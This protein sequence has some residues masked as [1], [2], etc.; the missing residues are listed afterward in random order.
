MP[1]YFFGFPDT[2][3]KM[4]KKKFDIAYVG[5]NWFREEEMT[6]FLKA[7]VESNVVKKVKIIG[8]D[9]DKYKLSRTPLDIKIG[10]SVL[11]EKLIRT[12]STGSI[13][14][15]LT[16]RNLLKHKLVTPRMFETFAAD[17]VPLF[18]DNFDYGDKIY[19]GV[20]KEFSSNESLMKDKIKNVIENHKKYIEF[21]NTA[22]KYL[23]SLHSYEN[24]MQELKRI[25]GIN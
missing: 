5:N 15:I 22:R 20:A 7:A 4:P 23:T 3:I 9:W 8:K 12:M 11:P 2:D 17:T 19:G 10:K 21:R 13:N 16:C 25:L 1:F 24:R 14:P 18:Y 6:N